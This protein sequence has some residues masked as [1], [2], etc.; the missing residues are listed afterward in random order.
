MG[1]PTPSRTEIA[2][3]L[4]ALRNHAKVWDKASDQLGTISDKTE[5]LELNRVEVGLFQSLVSQVNATRAKVQALANEGVK[6]MA[7]GGDALRKVANTYEREEENNTHK[8][9]KLY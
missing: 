9:E 5:N 6:E 1:E 7:E 8:I 4:E 2:F 3:S